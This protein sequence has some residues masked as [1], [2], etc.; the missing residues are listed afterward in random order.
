MIEINQYLKGLDGTYNGKPQPNGV[1]VWMISGTDKN[2]KKVEMKGTVN[3][4]R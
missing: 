1:Y 2:Y 3:L 4:L